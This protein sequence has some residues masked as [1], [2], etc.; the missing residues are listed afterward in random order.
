MQLHA[1]VV[2]FLDL[3]EV[4]VD[5]ILAGDDAVIEQLL[6]IARCGDKRFKG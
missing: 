6:Q 4:D 5:Q 1:M 2:V 3:G